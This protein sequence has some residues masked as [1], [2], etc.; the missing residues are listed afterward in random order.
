MAV[1]NCGHRHYL[2]P[3]RVS[4]LNADGGKADCNQ[5]R[6]NGVAT[7]GKMEL[8]LSEKC[9]ATFRKNVLQKTNQPCSLPDYG[10]AANPAA[11][12]LLPL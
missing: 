6:K 8:Q 11:S 3:K 1:D 7:F 4:I 9:L 12:V 10:Q 5:Q 2:T